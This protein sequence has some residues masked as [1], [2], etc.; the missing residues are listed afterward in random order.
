MSETQHEICEKR[1]IHT[2]VEILPEEKSAVSEKMVATAVMLAL[3]VRQRYRP[4]LLTKWAVTPSPRPG[5]YKK[6]VLP[7]VAFTRV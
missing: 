5:S 4:L 6:C 3:I 1:S 7:E 2:F